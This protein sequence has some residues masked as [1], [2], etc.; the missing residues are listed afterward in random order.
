M[1]VGA[2]FLLVLFGGL[3]RA[4][5][6]TTDVTDTIAF[7]DTASEASHGLATSGS[8]RVGSGGLRDQP[9][10]SLPLNASLRFSMA[11]EMGINPIVTL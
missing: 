10:R 9:F 6:L 8:T 1:M 4:A 5:A 2:T 11:V 3:Q 7:G